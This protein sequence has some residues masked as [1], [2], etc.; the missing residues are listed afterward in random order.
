[1]IPFENT[2]PYERIGSDIYVQYC[3]FCKAPNVLLPFK[4]R[5][6]EFLKEGVKKLLIF[7][8]CHNK[9]TL[10]GADQDYLLAGRP[11]RQYR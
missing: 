2:W 7:P 1:M 10:V 4:P 6:L 5:E 8:C 11:L 9:L 3:P